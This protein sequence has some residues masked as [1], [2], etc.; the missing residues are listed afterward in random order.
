[1]RLPFLANTTILLWLEEESNLHD[2][3][4]LRSLDVQGRLFDTYAY[5]PNNG[6]PCVYHFRHPAI[7]FYIKLL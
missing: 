7:L 5:F 3:L 6:Y 4:L 2:N 1:M